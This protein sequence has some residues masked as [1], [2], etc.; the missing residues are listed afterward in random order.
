[1]RRSICSLHVGPLAFDRR[2]VRRDHA[3]PAVHGGREARDVLAQDL[4]HRI[5]REASR[6]FAN[7]TS[8]FF[9]FSS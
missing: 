4:A 7:A 5:E 3:I 2:R 8:G 1:M 9:S 6:Y